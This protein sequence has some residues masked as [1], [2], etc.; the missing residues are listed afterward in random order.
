MSEEKLEDLV[1]SIA[2]EFQ[3][4]VVRYLHKLEEQGTD[5]ESSK[6]KLEAG[7]VLRHAMMNGADR[8]FDRYKRG[9]GFGDNDVYFD[10]AE[11]EDEERQAG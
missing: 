6:A 1:E 3:G 7:A 2:N 11:D 4:L 8:G 10:E 9:L 5:I